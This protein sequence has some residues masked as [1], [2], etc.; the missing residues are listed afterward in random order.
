[1]QDEIRRVPRQELMH[2]LDNFRRKMTESHPDWRMALINHKVNMYYLTGTMQEG[3]LV[4]TPD[5]AVLW[6]R[7]SY[8]RAKNESHFGD[9]RP[10]KSFRELADF[11]GIIPK[12]LYVETKTATLDWLNLLKKYLSFEETVSVNP[13]MDEL[14]IVKSGYELAC[15]KQAGENHRIALEE[16]APTLIHEGISE[17]ELA[18]Q[19]YTALLKMGSHGIARFNLPMGEDVI[20]F[21]S[22]GKSGLVR[23]AFDGP[24]G[25]GGTCI[26]VQTIGS[27]FRRLTENR[28]IYLDIPSGI[29]GYHTDKSVV[30]YFGDLSQD[31][32]GEEIARAH[33]HCLFLEQYT[34][35]LMRPGA[36][37]EDIYAAVMK[38]LDMRYS[39]AFMNG[40]KFLGHSIGLTMDEPPAIARGFKNELREGMTFAIEPKIALDGLGM[41]GTENTYYVTRDGAVSLTGAA[42]PLQQIKTKA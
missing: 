36:V 1:M 37:L 28:L 29:D 22:F 15:M 30:Y 19:I 40:G 20:G 5:D 32:R 27:A 6:V 33:E 16:T 18:V 23:T 10:M 24:G 26:A 3:V 31:P 39:D 38:K 17:A 42:M 35:S 14:R 21:A 13:I 34:A 9:I 12:A 41:V 11:Y 8:E 2:R 25:T 4:I 7:R